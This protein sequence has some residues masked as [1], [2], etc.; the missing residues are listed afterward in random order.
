M[1]YSRGEYYNALKRTAYLIELLIS[2]H[3][4]GLSV[5]LGDIEPPDSELIH[6]MI[7]SRRVPLPDDF[8]ATMKSTQTRAERIVIDSEY[9][10]ESVKQAGGWPHINIVSKEFRKV[11]DRVWA[12]VSDHIKFVKR[13]LS[14]YG[15]KLESV[16]WKHK[17]SAN[18]VMRY[19]REFSLRLAELILDA[20]FHTSQD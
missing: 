18:T 4:Q 1:N 14:R 6:A 3:P 5:L 10:N 9:F 11:E 13:S 15:S 8:K 7:N 12:I 19:R 20:D 16:A 2:C 17:V